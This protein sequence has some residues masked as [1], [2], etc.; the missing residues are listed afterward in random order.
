M[1]GP[2][3]YRTQAEKSAIDRALQS[4][5]QTRFGGWAAVNVASRIDRVLLPLTGGRLRTAPR[6]PLCVLH[7][8]GAKSGVPRPTPLLYTPDGENIV[9]IASKAG[10]TSHPAWYH[11]LMAQPDTEVEIDGRR[12]AMRA[13]EATGAERETLWAKAN[14]NYNGFARYQTRTERIIPVILLEPR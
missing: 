2:R 9:L 14:D 11:N 13:R 10:A 6:Q 12:L 1:A 3:T 5:F 7:T 4:F 8:V